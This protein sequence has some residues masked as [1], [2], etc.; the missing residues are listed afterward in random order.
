MDYCTFKMMYNCEQ[1][2][3]QF[4]DLDDGTPSTNPAAD[5]F[6]YFE[7]DEDLDCC[8]DIHEFEEAILRLGGLKDKEEETCEAP[9]QADGTHGCPEVDWT[10]CGPS[11]SI[12]EVLR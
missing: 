1:E 6:Q 3:H 7:G 12:D 11:Y 9:M 2:T 8:L 5:F 4:Y 10:E